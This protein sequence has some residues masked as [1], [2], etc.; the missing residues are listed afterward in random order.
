MPAT[1]VGASTQTVLHVAPKAGQSGDGSLERPYG[2]L[3]A[4]RDRI[5][6]LKA[7]DG[8]V[9][10]RPVIVELADGEYP[11][12]AAFCLDERDSGSPSAPIVYR[13]AHRGKAR[14]WGGID[15]VWRKPAADDPCLRLIPASVRG[16]VAVADLPSGPELP[17]FGGGRNFAN[18]HPVMLYANGCPLPQAAWPDAAAWSCL[19]EEFAHVIPP[20]DA[21]I[22]LNRQDPANRV[23]FRSD[24]PRLADWANEPDLWAHGM[25]QYEWDDAIAPV[26]AVDPSLQ[27]VTIDRK[28]ICYKPT[29]DGI[30]RLVNAFSEMDRPGEWAVDRKNR[31]VYLLSRPGLGKVRASWTETLV[32]AT[33]TAHVTFDGLSVENFRGNAFVFTDCRRAVVQ[34]C[35][36]SACSAWSVVFAGGSDCRAEGNDIFHVGEGGIV[37][38]GGNRERLTPAGTSA[39][40]N[41][42]HHFGERLWTYRPA[43]SL[44][45]LSDQLTFP[46]VGCRVEHNLIHHAR[47]M[48]VGFQGNDNYIGYNVIHDVCALTIDMGAVYGYTESDWSDMRGTVIERNLIYW[49]GRPR[50]TDM[51]VGVYLDGLSSGITVRENIAVR[52][53]LGFFQNGGQTNVFERN[54]AVGCLTPLKR[55]NL[56]YGHAYTR[57]D[58]PAWKNLQANRARWESEPWKSRFPEVARQAA[59]TNSLFAQCSLHSVVRDN[60]YAASG[61]AFY[62]ADERMQGYYTITNNLSVAGDPGFVDYRGLDFGFRPDSAAFRQ[63]GRSHFPEMGLFDSPLRASGAVRFG[64]D[65]SPAPPLRPLGI[66]AV[67]RIDVTLQDATF[68]EEAPMARELDNCSFAPGWCKERNRICAGDWRLSGPGRWREI[69]FSF[70]PLKDG[71]YTLSLMG[72]HAAKTCYDD[73]RVTGAKLVNGDFES[74]T[75]GWSKTMVCVGSTEN[76]DTRKPYGILEKTGVNVPAS[77]KRFAVASHA[78]IMNQQLRLTANRKVTVTFKATCWQDE[79]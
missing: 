54:L 73:I 11:I 1:G 32:S 34:A 58:S 37:L 43:V 25:W 36:V 51:I 78:L 30:Y 33:R 56:G 48:A 66:D 49:C 10:R 41:H 40:N 60:L 17:G 15:L 62:S 12:G 9:L 18:A 6:S 16:K 24:A 27:A 68:T 26:L 35:T 57:A 7:S 53:S 55:G 23:A 19:D 45:A 5:R 3:E 50:Y 63:L 46:C 20:T 65:V 69:R 29:K 70:V 75:D 52:A 44:G 42:V 8:G 39:V 38:S 22:A 13:A 76:A 79:D 74:G 31:R 72:I 47:H 28:A 59:L 67:A 2:T 4:A 61:E 71:D 64:A 14:L 21:I 77:G